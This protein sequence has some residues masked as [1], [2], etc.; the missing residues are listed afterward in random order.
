MWFKKIHKFYFEPY[1]EKL[2]QSAAVRNAQPQHNQNSLGLNQ[3][4]IQQHSPSPTSGAIS[5]TST[6]I[7]S[8]GA[9][10]VPSVLAAAAAAAAAAGN[11][12]QNQRL[13]GMLAILND[14][15]YQLTKQKFL[16]DFNFQQPTTVNVH[17]F[18]SKIKQWINLIETHLVNSMPRQQLLDERFKFVTQFC[19][20]TAAIELPGEYLIPRSTNYYVRI[21]R[22]LP[23][24]ESVER[25]NSY[26]R[27]ITIR[28]HNGKTYPFLISNEATYYYECRKEEHVMQLMRMANTYLSKQKETACRSLNFALPR[29]VSLSAEVNQS[30]LLSFIHANSKSFIYANFMIK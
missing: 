23:L 30:T 1:W 17:G 3:G 19:S 24:V 12:P 11:Q 20:S 15:N 21:S 6:P 13:R 9:G 5:G 26:C 16:A 28:G 10:I 25:Y 8:G 27:R 18:I 7:Q 2:Q 29:L 22:F 14:P 4:G